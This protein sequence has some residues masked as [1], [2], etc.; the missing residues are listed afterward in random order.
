M[1]TGDPG[2]KRRGATREKRKE[3]T[4]ALTE[5]GGGGRKKGTQAGG[6]KKKK[7]G[8]VGMNCDVEVKRN[9]PEFV[10][11]GRGKP[12]GDTICLKPS[13]E[14]KRARK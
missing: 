6:K 10:Y 3:K 11:M 5:A 7:G 12:G 4:H 2:K 9:G 8:K 14:K 1:C 13:G